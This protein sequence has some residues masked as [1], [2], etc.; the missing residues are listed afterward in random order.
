MCS[1]ERIQ[2]GVP[3]L[4]GMLGGGL[5]IPSLILVAEDIGAGKVTFCT[6]FL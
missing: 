1:I 6:R 5:P 3:G 2:T 4:D